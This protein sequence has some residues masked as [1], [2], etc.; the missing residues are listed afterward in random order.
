MPYANNS[1][2]RKIGPVLYHS[3]LGPRCHLYVSST[4]VHY[5]TRYSFCEGVYSKVRL[6]A[7]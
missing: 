7:V 6:R 4:P 5:A 1:K 3:L 2:A